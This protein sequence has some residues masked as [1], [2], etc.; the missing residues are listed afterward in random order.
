MIHSEKSRAEDAEYDRTHYQCLICLDHTWL[1]AQ[2]CDGYG[3]GVGKVLKRDRLPVSWCG[4]GK[5][6]QGHSYTPGRCSCWPRTP[7][8]V[9]P[10]DDRP[11]RRNANSRE[12]A[13]GLSTRSK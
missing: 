7:L 11:R 4:D 8:P 1:P 5:H 6:H 13:L 10:T 3:E 12:T 2:W 9:P